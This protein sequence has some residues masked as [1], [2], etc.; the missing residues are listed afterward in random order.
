MAW[1]TLLAIAATVVLWLLRV[2]D[3][4]LARWRDI[5]F[6]ARLRDAKA[7]GLVYERA[8]ARLR[9]DAE[10]GQLH[11]NDE[12]RPVFDRLTAEAKGAQAAE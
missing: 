3:Q 2:E 10:G 6:G 11:I 7:R 9:T 12:Y 4:R 8:L 5:S 1:V